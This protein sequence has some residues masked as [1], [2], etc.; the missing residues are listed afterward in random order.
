MK[1]T[2][3]AHT[4][5]GTHIHPLALRRPLFVNVG[6]K[7]LGT[8]IKFPRFPEIPVGRFPDVLRIS[9]WFQESSNWNFWKTLEFWEHY[10]NSANLLIG[11]LVWQLIQPEEEGV[12]NDVFVPT[13]KPMWTLPRSSHV[14]RSLLSVSGC[15]LCP[16]CCCPS[17]ES[18]A[19]RYLSRWGS[20]W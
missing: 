19:S 2:P 8:F 18:H 4:Q 7:F 15:H 17:S 10:Q 20:S 12:L 1:H 11:L 3:H 6:S 9:S 13:G 16:S 5:R 14:C